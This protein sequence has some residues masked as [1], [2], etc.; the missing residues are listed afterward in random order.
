MCA[1]LGGYIA[2]EA[3]KAITNK[4]SPT[5]QLFYYDATEVLPEFKPKEHLKDFENYLKSI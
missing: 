4:F 3:V 2:Q 1:F 5:K